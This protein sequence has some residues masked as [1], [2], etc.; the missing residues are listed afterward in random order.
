MGMTSSILGFWMSTVRML[1][2]MGKKNFLPEAFTKV[3]KHQ[4][5]ILPNIFLLVISLVFI[6]L[7]NAGTFMNDFFNLMSFGCACAY[8]ITMVSAV[9][10]RHKHP[11]WYKNNKNVVKGGDF[12]RILAMVIMIAIAFFCTLG[13]GRR[14]VDLVRRLSGRRRADLACGWSSSRWK[15]TS[16][17]IETPDGEQEF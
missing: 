8:A 17:V 6:L 7:Q 12:F 9:R 3:N 5:P 10:M 15:K 11:E 4:Q 2:S 14:L 13:Q 16:V 1:Y